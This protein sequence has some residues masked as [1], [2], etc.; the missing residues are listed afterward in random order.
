MSFYSF[1]PTH[2]TRLIELRITVQSPFFHNII[3]EHGAQI[4][5]VSLIGA[6]DRVATTG[7][8]NKKVT[9]L[10]T[11]YTP[12]FYPHGRREALLFNPL[13]QFIEFAFI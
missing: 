8:A 11:V 2:K 5:I 1:N 6:I 4:N 10:T 9:L 3:I 13:F 7:V 12:E